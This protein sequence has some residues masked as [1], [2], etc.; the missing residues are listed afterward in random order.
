M[1]S[2]AE[3]RP[4][5]D[6]FGNSVMKPTMSSM[7]RLDAAIAPVSMRAVQWHQSVHQGIRTAPES[8]KEGRIGGG[9][10]SEST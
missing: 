6:L 8:M 4:V 7:I 10:F 5:Y 2:R 1:I 3:A 9:T